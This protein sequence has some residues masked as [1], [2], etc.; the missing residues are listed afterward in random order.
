M[1]VVTQ[2]SDLE[3]NALYTL[4]YITLHYIYIT[5]ELHAHYIYIKLTLQL[6]LHYMTSHCIRASVRA[7]KDT[8]IHVIYRFPRRPP[9]CVLKNFDMANPLKK[10]NA[11][12]ASGP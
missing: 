11:L 6:H 3:G 10:P 1:L 5:S 8:Y 2:C 12:V 9:P 4:H 7:Y